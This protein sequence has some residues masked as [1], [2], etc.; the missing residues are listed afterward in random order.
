MNQ[1]SF[2]KYAATKLKTSRQSSILIDD[3]GW[4]I[5]SPLDVANEFNKYFAFVFTVDDGNLPDF[6]VR[7]NKELNSIRFDVLSLSKVLKKLKPSLFFGLDNIPNVFL[8]R[9]ER[10]ITWPLSIL[11][12][13]SLSAN[14][15]PALWKMAKVVPLH[16]KGS[17]ISPA[18]Y[19]PISLVSSISEVMERVIIDQ[20][21]IFLQDNNLITH[22]QYGFQSGSSTVTQ[23]IE[24]HTEWVTSQN[25]G[26]ATDVIY[27]DNTNAFASVIH[28][29]AT[30]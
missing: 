20:V 21:Q 7:V 30:A 28:S 25:N 6:P 24:C 15:I 23:L 2:F 29:F 19:R 26:E 5:T 17:T 8:R 4:I 3:S 27:L 9:T 18:N 14:Y 12:E 16:K 11:F 13:R 1:S 22:A 10:S